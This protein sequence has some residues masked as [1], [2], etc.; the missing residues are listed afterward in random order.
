MNL[1][2]RTCLDGIFENKVLKAIQQILSIKAAGF[3]VYTTRCIN[4][5]KQLK[6]EEKRTITVMWSLK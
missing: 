2:E 6:F 4:R 1:F 3:N 5:D